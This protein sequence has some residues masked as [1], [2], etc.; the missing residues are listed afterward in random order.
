MA[1]KN[2]NKEPKVEKVFESKT[3][4]QEKVLNDENSLAEEGS[5]NIDDFLGKA[6]ETPDDGLTEKQRN[7]LEK[8]NNV[9][10]KI[11]KILQS[12]NIEIVDENFDDEYES[13]SS[14]SVDGQSQQDYDSL[15]AMFGGKDSGK[16]DELT[17]TIDDFDYTYIGQ[18]L[19]EYD[20]MHMKNIKRVKIIRK[21]SPKLRKFLLISSLVLVIAIGAVLAFVFT[22]KEPVYLKSVTLNQTERSYYL[23]DRFDYTGLYFIAEYSDGRIEKV[24]LEASHLNNQMSTRIERVGDSNEE[25]IFSYPN[26]ANLVFTYQG[27]NVNYDVKVDKKKELA[28]CALYTKGIFNIEANGYI[29]N[30]VLDMYIEYED[31]G[32]EITDLS[33]QFTIWI[34]SDKCEYTKDGFKT[35]NGTTMD[36]VIKIVYGEF[37]VTLQNDI[38]FI[39]SKID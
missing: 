3:D 38:N 10:S 31:I 21:K 27:F 9:K 36:S 30:D 7:K 25:I 19:E 2:K 35:I 12:S 23:N 1:K 15:K 11:S 29:T 22:R 28:I 16:K 4:D 33:S 14:D 6:D 13:G 18:Y 20:L 5:S 8:L 39:S 17:L 37:V 32:V 26:N 24:K 34:G